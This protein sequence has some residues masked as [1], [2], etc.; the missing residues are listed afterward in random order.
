MEPI[1][2][3]MPSTNLYDVKPVVQ[4]WTNPNYIRQDNSTLFTIKDYYYPNHFYPNMYHIS[5]M[6]NTHSNKYVPRTRSVEGFDF[7]I[8]NNVD[9]I[10]LWVAIIVLVIIYVRS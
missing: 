1:R 8:G 2:P 4:S 7:S 10:W 5:A 9:N 3:T 6:E